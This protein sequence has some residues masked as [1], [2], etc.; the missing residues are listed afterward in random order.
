[1][2]EE[3]EAWKDSLAF[4][5]TVEVVSGKARTLPVGFNPDAKFLKYHT[6]LLWGCRKNTVK[7]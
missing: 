4:P 6:L 3:V 2:D 5:R 7:L 1:M